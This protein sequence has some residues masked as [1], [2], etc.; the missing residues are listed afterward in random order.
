M[1]ES[2]PH[3]PKMAAVAVAAAAW[4]GS[5]PVVLDRKHER[6]KRKSIWLLGSAST[7]PDSIPP[8]PL[9]NSMD[10]WLLMCRNVFLR[11]III[12]FY[13][14]AS[15][16][17]NSRYLASE[18]AGQVCMWVESIYRHSKSIDDYALSALNCCSFSVSDDDDDAWNS[19]LLL[20]LS[21]SFWQANHSSSCW[22]F[23]WSTRKPTE[24]SRASRLIHSTFNLPYLG[25]PLTQLSKW[26]LM[27][28]M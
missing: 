6:A 14:F 20:L 8:H 17:L 22:I 11:L 5:N 2:S 15:E 16:K 1:F 13:M 24:S 19:F 28:N 10:G 18:W 4:L 12:Q 27:S 7:R 9:G 21:P 23:S 25:P 3:L 26:G